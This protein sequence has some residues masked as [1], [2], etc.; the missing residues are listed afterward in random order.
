MQRL[1]KLLLLTFVGVSTLSTLK[2]VPAYPGII[3][4]TQSDG[5][6]LN[7][8][9]Y[10]DEYFSWARTTD[11]Y[12]IKRNAIGDY[13]YMVK[14]SYGDLVLS[15][16]IAHN[17]ELRSQAEQLFLSTLETKMFYSES[18]MSIVQQAIAI[19]K[20]EEE[21][22]SRAFPT[23]GDRKLICILIGYTD[24][25]FVKTQAEFNALFN[26]VGYTTGGATGS[27]KDYYLENS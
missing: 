1:I 27:V 12:T 22:S 6:T 25:P 13:V 14:D 18:Q 26:E 9:L 8:Y 19:R 7:Y 15:E 2:A 10:G 20:A 23:T 5:T 3:Q 17:P 21:K 11:D 4:Q 24:R 16:V